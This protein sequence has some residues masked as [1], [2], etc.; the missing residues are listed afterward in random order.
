KSRHSEVSATGFTH[1]GYYSREIARTNDLGATIRAF[2]QLA[3]RARPGDD[4]ERWRRCDRELLALSRA[5][6]RRDGLW[7]RIRLGSLSLE[8][9]ER[10]R[11]HAVSGGWTRHGGSRG[12]DGR[13]HWRRRAVRTADIRRRAVRRKRHGRRSRRRSRHGRVRRERERRIQFR[14]G[15]VRP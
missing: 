11:R 6:A 12:G 15:W 9:Q 14:N 1:A 7:V 2:S 8:T 3:R 13:R 5:R 10:S 4:K